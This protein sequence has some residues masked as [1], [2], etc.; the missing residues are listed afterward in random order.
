MWGG[1]GKRAE[2]LYEVRRT[3]D[4]S[5]SSRGSARSGG[6]GT[7]TYASTSNS[8]GGSRETGGTQR[9]STTTSNTETGSPGP[10]SRGGGCYLFQMRQPS[11]CGR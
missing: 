5:G 4:R 11:G 2:V 9:R 7:G 10:C 1:F 8:G 6:C 3:G